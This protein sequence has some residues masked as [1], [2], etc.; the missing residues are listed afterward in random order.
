QSRYPLLFLVNP[1][2]LLAAFRHRFAGFAVGL[3][4]V[5]VISIAATLSGS[6]PLGLVAGADLSERTLLLQIFLAITCL[7]TLPVVV[8]LAERGRLVAH[9]RASERNYRILAHHSRDL[10]V[11]MR[12]DAS[13]LYISP[14]VSELL[15]WSRGELSKSRWDL[16]H[17]EDRGK[18]V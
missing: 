4:I 1:P 7:T 2:L 18:L 16:I 6:G 3:A 17:A 5:V 12:P 15:G 10:V 13:A 11:R 14:S 9:M 8:V